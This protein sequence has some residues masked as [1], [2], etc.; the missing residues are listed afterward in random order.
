MVKDSDEQS[1]YS[2][3]ENVKVPTVVT[4]DILEV[5]ENKIQAM[6]VEIGTLKRTIK[7]L[8]GKL[9]VS[10]GVIA[11]VKPVEVKPVEVLSCSCLDFGVGCSIG[12]CVMSLCSL[13]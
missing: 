6:N 9:K 13:I 12:M 1:N 4:T 11:E 7:S 2:D 10:N 3:D 5:L 8:K